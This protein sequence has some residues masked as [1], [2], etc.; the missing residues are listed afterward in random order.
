MTAMQ[1]LFVVAVVAGMAALGVVST[2][3]LARLFGKHERRV[4]SLV[5]ILSTLGMFS[6]CAGFSALGGADAVLTVENQTPWPI[7]I[8]EPYSS[9]RTIPP[10]LTDHLTGWGGPGWFNGILDDAEVR[11]GRDLEHRMTVGAIIG[12]DLDIVIREDGERSP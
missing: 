7:E 10:G 5:L 1:P 6:A 11:W 3:F 8:R 4:L 12:E 2:P 9:S